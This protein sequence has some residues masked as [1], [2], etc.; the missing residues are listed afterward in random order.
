MTGIK[1]KGCCRPTV[2]PP[3]PEVEQHTRSSCTGWS[4]CPGTWKQVHT[5][6]RLAYPV[7][8]DQQGQRYHEPLD[9]R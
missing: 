4:F 1:V 2:P 8:Q 9:L 5:E 7:F 3:Y 6:L